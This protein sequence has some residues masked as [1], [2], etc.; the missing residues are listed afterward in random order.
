MCKVL[1]VSRS[2]YYRWFCKGPSKR[3]VE[4]SLFTDLIKEIF[5]LSYQTYGSPRITEELRRKGYCIS[6]RRVARLMR[7]NGWRSK[8]KK[9]FRV[10]TDSNHRYPVC[11]NLLNRNFNP[12]ELNEVWVSDITYIKVSNRWLYLT[13]II[14]LYDRQVIGWSL[15]TNLYTDKTIIPAWKMAISKRSITKP[16]LF[17]SDRGI[18]YAAKEFRKVIKSHNLVTQSMSRKANCWDNAVAES[19]FKT[20]KIELIYQRKFN[21]IEL[22]K[23]AIFE[24]IEIWYNRKRLHSSL[25]YKTPREVELEF[26][27]IKNVA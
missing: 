21:S 2:S 12:K 3:S 8:L 18:Q 19:F 6:K 23:S 1:K 4:N 9:K 7:V 25:D 11:R 13:T 26:Y 22:A 5:D 15:S 16:L 24:Y 17:H 27:Q 10:T 14:D 20:I